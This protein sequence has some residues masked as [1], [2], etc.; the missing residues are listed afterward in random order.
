MFSSESADSHFS[1]S[2]PHDKAE[3]QE[4]RR[5]EEQSPP[6]ASLQRAGVIPGKSYP[7]L[8]GK[9]YLALAQSFTSHMTLGK[10]SLS[11]PQFLSWK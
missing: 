6:A 10:D 5:L 1:E 11:E 7:G 3:H 2:V 9:S 8:E 4:L